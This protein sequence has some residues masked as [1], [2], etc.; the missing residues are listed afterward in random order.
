MNLL[1]KGLGGQISIDYHPLYI[2]H[3]DVQL[4]DE[5]LKVEYNINK[6]YHASILPLA[7][8]FNI[9]IRHSSESL[10]VVYGLCYAY[11]LIFESL[12][13]FINENKLALEPPT[14]SQQAWLTNMHQLIENNH[15]YDKYKMDYINN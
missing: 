15:K 10:L 12:N 14:S 8:W 11:K 1:A 6:D 3:I 9:A 13:Q 5:G 4:S 2:P 7:D